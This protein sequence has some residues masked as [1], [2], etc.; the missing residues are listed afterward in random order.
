MPQKFI[1]GTL[2]K[3]PSLERQ[4]AKKIGMAEVDVRLALWGYMAA[5]AAQVKTYGFVKI[6][7][8]ITLKLEKIPA[9]PARVFT[10]PITYKRHSVPA[11]QASQKL[12]AHPTKK[13]KALIKQN[14]PGQVAHESLTT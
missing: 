1:N 7:K 10:N 9:K 11:K 14:A 13:L 3:F 2:H 5:A 8:M 6:G 4:A 12:A